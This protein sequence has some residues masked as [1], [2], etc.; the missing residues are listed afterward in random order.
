[1]LLEVGGEAGVVL[2]E[3]RV[4]LAKKGPCAAAA[5]SLKYIIITDSL[6]GNEREGEE[7]LFYKK[8]RKC[9]YN[10]ILIFITHT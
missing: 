4:C 2:D 7:A 10:H 9:S 3:A 8:R 5:S 1:M 6:L